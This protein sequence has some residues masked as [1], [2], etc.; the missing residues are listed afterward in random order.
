MAIV[1]AACPVCSQAL[2]DRD[3][4]GY[5]P[6][7]PAFCGGCLTVFKVA[8]AYGEGE[9]NV[10][11]ASIEVLVAASGVRRMLERV[12]RAQADGTLLADV[13]AL[14]ADRDNAVVLRVP[15][16]H[17]IA[18]RAFGKRVR[19]LEDVS[20]PLDWE[21]SRPAPNPARRPGPLGADPL[22]TAELPFRWPSD[23]SLWGRPLSPRQRMRET[24]FDARTKDGSGR[25]FVPMEEA[26]PVD[27]WITAGTVL[28]V[29]RFEPPRLA[30]KP[31]ELDAFPP[32]IT[33]RTLWVQLS[34]IEPA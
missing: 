15:Q 25:L 4:F 1:D 11:V 27:A 6:E 18:R 19:L 16:I 8:L 17:D 9:S 22:R 31:P 26:L 7:V 14:C 12:E 28:P 20:F 2:T 3:F 13:R 23:A 30:C 33:T 24:L 34:L 32:W 21:H 10:T 5:G 29:D